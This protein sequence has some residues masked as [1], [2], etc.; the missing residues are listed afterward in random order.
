MRRGLIHWLSMW[1]KDDLKQSRANV[2][3]KVGTTP[4]LRRAAFDRGEE[5]LPGMSDPPAR[6]TGWERDSQR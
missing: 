1:G 5:P 4:D 3:A 6:R 2:A